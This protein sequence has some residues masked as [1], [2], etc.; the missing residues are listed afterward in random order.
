MVVGETSELLT[1]KF[2]KTIIN[3]QTIIKDKRCVK[4]RRAMSVAYL[5]LK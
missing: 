2:N 5:A 1:K 3:T 4:L